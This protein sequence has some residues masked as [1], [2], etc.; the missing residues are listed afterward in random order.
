MGSFYCT[1]KYLQNIPHIWECCTQ[2]KTKYNSGLAQ[3]PGEWLNA[4][5]WSIFCVWLLTEASNF[6]NEAP[7]E[8]RWM[9]V[10]DIESIFNNYFDTTFIFPECFQNCLF[11]YLF[12]ISHAVFSQAEVDTSV[13]NWKDECPCI[14]F[15]LF[16][17]LHTGMCL[18]NVHCGFLTCLSKVPKDFLMW[19]CY[20]TLASF[21]SIER[22]LT[23]PRKYR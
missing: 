3:S 2:R 6:Q 22:P 13:L 16:H 19:L 1:W 4:L 8:N 15:P 18:L 10:H 20:W 23:L 12:W 7:T 11:Q 14:F 17:I 21:L 9:T 5:N